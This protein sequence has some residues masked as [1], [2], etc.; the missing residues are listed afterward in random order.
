MTQT[1]SGEADAA[2]PQDLRSAPGAIGDLIIGYRAAKAL[3]TAARLELFDRLAGECREL[4]GICAELGTKPRPTEALLDALTGLGLLE[5]QGAAW[6]AT[7]LAREHLLSESP[8]SLASVLKLQDLLWESWGEFERVL[9]EGRPRASLTERI[10]SQPGFTEEYI[11]SM[12]AIAQRPA[13]E[14][15]GA[16]DFSGAT[17]LLDVGGGSGAYAL[18]FLE[19]WPALRADLID[20]P[21]TL[22]IARRFCGRSPHAARLRFMV[23]D[24]R[25]WEPEPEAY[26]IVLLS[27][28]THD[29]GEAVNL[30]LLR[31]AYLALRPGGRV[32]VHDFMTERDRTQPLFASMFS[33]HLTVYTEEGRVYSVDEYRRFVRSAGFS[34]IE[35]RPIAAGAQ[36]ASRLLVGR[37][38]S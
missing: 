24:Y 18:A 36:N 6:R 9:R 14:I 7:E 29:E 25:V 28:V 23:G 17:N 12:F 33:V 35:D 15:A 37:K 34:S 2:R 8:A 10:A 16:A 11:R 27:H 21:E 31:R 1:L 30:D 38:T 13:A 4:D 20:L 3:F 5:K 22:R 26:D 32:L 19:R